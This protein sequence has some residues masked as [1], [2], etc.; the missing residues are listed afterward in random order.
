MLNDDELAE[1]RRRKMELMMERAKALPVREPLANGIVNQLTDATFWNTVS[2]TKIALIDFYGEWCSP[3]KAL[4]PIFAALSADYKG[5]VF[6]GKID[7]DKN[8]QV[9][10]QFGVQ[11]VPMIIAF[12]DG[13]PIGKLP[14]LRPYDQYDQVIEQLT[15]A[16]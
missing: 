2:Q 14:G 8:P 10:I 7:I 16:Q 1:I 9:T 4:A 13:Q 3:C 5:E 12:K 11:S 15:K 6:F